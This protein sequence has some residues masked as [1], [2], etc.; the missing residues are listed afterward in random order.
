MRIPLKELIVALSKALDFVEKELLGIT[1]NHG[2][3]TAYVAAR[4]CRAMNMTDEEVFDMACCSILHDNAL[5]AY[6]LEAGPGDLRRLEHFKTHCLIGE[7]NVMA[8][9]FPED[10]SGIILH[11]HENWDGS[12]FHGLVG[13]QIPL[14]A[15]ILRMA[16]NMDL[17]LRMGDGRQS[18][19]DEAAEHVKRH[20]GT[21]YSPAVVKTL[22]GIMDDSF[23]E[24]LKDEN[25]GRALNQAMPDLDVGLSTKQLLRICNIFAFII[26]AKSPFTRIHS[27]GLASLMRKLGNHYGLSGE[28]L[29]KLTIAAY[30]H[31][32]GKLSIPV[33][34]L[35][36][37]GPLTDE[38][39]DRMREHSSITADILGEVSGLEEVT[40][41]CSR[42]HE[43]LDGCGYPYGCAGSDLNFECRLLTCGDIYQALTEDRPY[44]PG[45]AHPEAIAIMEQMVQDGQI[46]GNI[47]KTLKEVVGQ[48]RRSVTESRVPACGGV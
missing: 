5:T 42:H 33:S 43:K 18:I 7:Q 1:T 22:L 23:V 30:L 46:D 40:S 41:W 34:I 21:I 12:G 45:M 47:V 14:R 29:D 31:D 2:K 35:E 44:R 20:S 4:V 25:I 6:M 27:T 32:L 26:D 10:V 39:M 17:E 28:H 48:P 37:P 11:H 16:D 13:D 15:A 38:E 19:T 9:P 3:R 8:I 24:D 36:K